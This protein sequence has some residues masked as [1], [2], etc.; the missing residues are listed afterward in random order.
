MSLTAAL[1]AISAAGALA[2]RRL[3]RHDVRAD[4]HDLR[5]EGGRRIAEITL[6]QSTRCL[7]RT[8]PPPCDVHETVA[9]L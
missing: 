6:P 9:V 5:A 7:Q 2:P 1:F 8:S 4:R 3:G